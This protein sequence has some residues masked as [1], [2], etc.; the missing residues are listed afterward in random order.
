MT[1][2]KKEFEYHYNVNVYKYNG[3]LSSFDIYKSW[4]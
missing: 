3:L 2:M 1:D 4:Y